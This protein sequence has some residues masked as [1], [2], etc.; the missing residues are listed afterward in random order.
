MADAYD[1]AKQGIYD[2]RAA[3]LAAMAAQGTQGKALYDSTQADLAA[4]RSNAV[5]A[6]LQ[7][8]QNRG[9]PSNMLASIQSQVEAPYTRQSMNVNNG[10][11]AEQTWRNNLGDAT[12]NYMDQSAAAIPG[13]RIIAQTKAADAKAKSDLQAQKDAASLARSTASKARSG[14][15][16][17]GGSKLSTGLASA[18]SKNAATLYRADIQKDAT[19]HLGS[20]SRG[21]A[22]LNDVLSKGSYEKSIAYLN[23]LADQGYFWRGTPSQPWKDSEGKTVRPLDYSAIRHYLDLYYAPP[24]DPYLSAAQSQIVNQ[25]SY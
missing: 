23:G 24:P 18:T 8:A 9:A 16:L 3:I 21:E 19:Q 11:I 6:A 7:E 17:G 22:A 10:A 25:G 5:N 12:A 20:G 13:L 15:S 4:Q 2:Q 1:A 14:S